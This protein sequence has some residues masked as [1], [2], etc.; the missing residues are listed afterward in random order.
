[1]HGATH[2][3]LNELSRTSPRVATPLRFAATLG[4][5]V[6][7]PSGYIIIVYTTL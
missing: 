2:S 6:T 4:Y 1:M 3:G 7:S 5:R